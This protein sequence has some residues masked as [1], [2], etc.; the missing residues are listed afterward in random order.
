MSQE[1]VCVGG[2]G[3]G[4]AE[5]SCRRIFACMFVLVALRV[6]ERVGEQKGGSIVDI[7]SLS[8]VLSAQSAYRPRAGR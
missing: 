6:G 2:G 1:S 8:V 5:E 4:Y 7:G 3:A